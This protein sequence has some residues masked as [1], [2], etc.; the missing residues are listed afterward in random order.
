MLAFQLRSADARRN[1][2]TTQ[3]VASRAA[4]G[5]HAMTALE[6]RTDVAIVLSGVTKQGS[7]VAQQRMILT[8]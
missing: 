3:R 8:I 4:T 2:L 7:K 1:W 5:A 6:T